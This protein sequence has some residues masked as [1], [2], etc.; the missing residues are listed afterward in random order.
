MP[1]KKKLTE[2]EDAALLRR[3]F[4]KEALAIAKAVANPKNRQKAK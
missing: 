3:L 4:P 2:L 1:K